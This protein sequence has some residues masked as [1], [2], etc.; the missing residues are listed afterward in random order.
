[1][2][3]L[4][5]VSERV[6]RL[7]KYLLIVAAVLVLAVLG[8]VWWLNHW[9]KSP[10]THAYLERELSKQLKFPL[11]FKSLDFSIWS[12][13]KAHGVTVPDRGGNFLAADEL[14]AKHRFGPLLRG[15]IALSQ[16]SIDAAK[17]T[18]VQRPDGSWKLPEL[19]EDLKA[20]LEAKKKTKAMTDKPAE[21]APKKN[22]EPDVLL[23]KILLTNATADFVDAGGKPF[24][25]VT[26]LRLNLLNTASAEKIEGALVVGRA[27][28]H[29]W[30]AVTELSATVHQSKEKGLFIENL[31]GKVGGGKLTGSYMRKAEKASSKFSSRLALTGVDL[32]TAAMDGDAPP[33]NLNG[34]MTAQVFIKGDNDDWKLAKGEGGVTLEN[35]SLRKINEIEWLKDVGDFLQIDSTS[36]LTIPEAKLDA[37]INSGRI[38]IDDLKLSAPPLMVTAKGT[39]KWDGKFDLAA[40]FRAEAGFIAKRTLLE[41][42]FQPVE[43]DGFRSV[44]FSLRGSL[45]KPKQDLLEKLTGT[46][47]RKMQKFIAGEA[48][49]DAITD[50][51]PMAKPNKDA[52]EPKEPKEPKPKKPKNPPPPPAPEPDAPSEP[53]KP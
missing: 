32:V 42:Q 45:Q 2:A 46:K 44:D 13:L 27:V 50:Q 6:K 3:A 26:A 17:F 20:E 15:Q 22:K 1:V 43:A 51:L 12:G 18:W 23:E 52:A 47:D 53:D 35:G 5:L 10:E 30:M 24:A 31:A 7:F 21:P 39:A 37:K 28:L 36:I 25:S 11:R 4:R 33:P 40:K 41:P 16:V 49:F 19:P 9:V 38:F 8:G 14:I 29:G 34:K 48:A